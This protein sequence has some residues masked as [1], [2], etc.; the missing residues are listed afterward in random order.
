MVRG[1]TVSVLSV[2][3]CLAALAARG[4]R[5]E[6]KAWMDRSK[7]PVE[8]ASELLPELSVAEKIAMTFATHTCESWHHM[9]GQG[10]WHGSHSP[11]HVRR[12]SKTPTA[13]RAHH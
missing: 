9:V 13:C 5:A 11:A 12:D 4:V 10:L 2:S 3:L 1:S 7:S 6:K 8:R